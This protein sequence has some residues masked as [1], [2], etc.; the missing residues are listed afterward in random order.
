MS[1]VGVLSALQPGDCAPGFSLRA[2]NRFDARDEPVVFSLA[3]MLRAG[4]LI[5]EFL[6][7]TW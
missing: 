4:P 6:R 5:V 3:E 1:M 2:A 7:G